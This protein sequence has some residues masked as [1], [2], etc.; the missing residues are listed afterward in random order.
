MG[1]VQTSV[2]HETALACT[3]HNLA[4]QTHTPQYKYNFIK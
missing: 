2:T 4:C 1:V 3:A